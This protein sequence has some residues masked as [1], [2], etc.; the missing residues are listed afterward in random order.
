MCFEYEISQKEEQKKA[1]EREKKL[2]Q[3]LSESEK[4]EERPIPA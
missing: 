4:S 3:H 2:L 1:I